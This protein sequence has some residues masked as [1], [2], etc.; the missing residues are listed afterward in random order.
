MKRKTQT[1]THFPVFY[2]SLSLLFLIPL[3]VSS[4][5]PESGQNTVLDNFLRNVLEKEQ[6]VGLGACLVKNNTIVWEGYYGYADLERGLMLNR[7]NIFQLSSLSKTVTAF[8]LMKLYEDGKIRLDDDINKYLPFSFRSP[9][10]PDNEITFRMLLNHTSGL[11]DVTAT[12][13]VVPSGVGRPQSSI[14]DSDMTLDEY[15]SQLLVPGGKYYS[16]EYFSGNEPG[17]VYSYSNIGYS[18]LGYLVERISGEDFAL[19]TEKNIFGPLDLKNIAWHLRD[20]DT[21]RVI[22]SYRFSPDDTIPV[23]RKIR[24]FGEPGYPAGMLRT[25]MDDF[26]KFII[27]LLNRGEYQ[28]TRLL[29]PETVNM[30]LYPQNM[31]NIS[32]KSYKLIDRGLTWQIVDLNGN[33]Y[34]EMN[35]FS[36]GIYTDA[37]FSP[38]LNTGII[39]YFTGINMKNM[40]AIPEIACTLE[41]A[42][43]EY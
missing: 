42:L 5:Q 6:Y 34:Y 13:L 14:G 18:L 12:G 20:L 26:S 2:L 19:F 11:A 31:K 8:A 27:T 30:I 32:S 24:H 7:E 25:S 22:F 33:K 16:R 40:Q 15:I 28:S 41:T 38:D 36:G 4:R 9:Y 23:Y 21:G 35:G 29:K 43:K 39:F 3:L 1:G 10:F 17:T 37:L